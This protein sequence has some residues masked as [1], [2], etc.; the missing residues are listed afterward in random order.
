MAKTVSNEKLLE[1]LLVYGNAERAAKAL[2][3]TRNAIYKRLQD[4][5]FR[6]QYTAAQTA[7]INAVAL[8]LTAAVSDA[9]GALHD[10]ATDDVATDSARISASNALLTHCN[11][12]VE[13]ASI[14]RRL[15]ALEQAS[16]A[17]E[18]INER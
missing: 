7:V 6:A 2:N 15:D 8:E 9:V 10:V 14:L 4:E 12:Y 17:N 16:K 3:I 1:T 5:T 13:T 18:N 11:R